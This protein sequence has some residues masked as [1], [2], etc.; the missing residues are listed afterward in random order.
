MGHRISHETYWRLK[1]ARKRRGDKTP[2]PY[3]GVHGRSPWDYWAGT[4]RKGV[5]MEGTPGFL[6]RFLGRILFGEKWIHHKPSSE[7]AAG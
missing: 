3:I 1:H 6:R 4:N 7:P 5:K 2:V